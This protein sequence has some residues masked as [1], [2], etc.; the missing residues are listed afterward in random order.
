MF[1]NKRSLEIVKLLL[2]YDKLEIL[3][4]ERLLEIKKRT[5]I[6]NLDSINNFLKSNSL[7]EIIFENQTLFIRKS[8]KKL[9]KNLI[10][11]V[12]LSAE[13]RKDYILIKLL[14]KNKVVLN[15]ESTLLDIS[16]R[17]LNYDLETLKLSLKKDNIELYSVP[18]QGIYIRGDEFNIRNI[19]TNYLT[20]YFIEKDKNLKLINNLIESSF[21]KDELI[22]AKKL[23][24][25]LIKKLDFLLP[26][27]DFYSIIS[28]YLV[29]NLRKIYVNKSYINLDFSS[30]KSEKYFILLKNNGFQDLE[31]EELLSIINILKN[32]NPDDFDLKYPFIQKATIF[33]QELEKLLNTKLKIT[34]ELLIKVSNGIRIGE[35]KAKVN[36]SEKIIKKPFEENNNFIFNAVEEL[37]K[38]QIPNFHNEDILFLA[39]VIK[40][41]LDDFT[42]HKNLKKNIIIIDNSFDHLYGKLLKNYIN[43]IYNVNIIT[44]IDEYKVDIIHDYHN[45]LDCIITLEELTIDKEIFSYPILKIDLNDLWNSTHI[46]EKSGVI[47]KYLSK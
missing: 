14:T 33:L 6:N 18:Q 8:D 30:L 38:L 36:I 40:E 25:N 17:T 10:L 27:E 42:I 29:S 23:V 11:I 44:I 37:I 9:I 7:A 47:R 31:Y 15:H 46:L 4:I 45:I 24:L 39:I 21:G 32:I 1:L 20:K 16:R 13:E 35:F 12:P 19:L 28:I 26:P 3:E 41:A 43:T 5:I 2:K 22:L 34:K